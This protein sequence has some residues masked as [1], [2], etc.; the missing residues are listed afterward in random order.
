MRID[1]R[2]SAGS[3]I[4]PTWREAICSEH[5]F[6][7]E[8]LTRLKF[9]WCT[10]FLFDSLFLLIAISKKQCYYVLHVVVRPCSMYYY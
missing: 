10:V 6:D 9:E 5:H 2:C 1:T 7:K 8:W 4:S 3:Q